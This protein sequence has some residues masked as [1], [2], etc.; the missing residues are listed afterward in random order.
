MEGFL[1]SSK[2]SFLCFFIGMYYKE[3][4]VFL[5]KDSYLL[6]RELRE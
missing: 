4:I 1:F 2:C 5:N 6:L 3:E